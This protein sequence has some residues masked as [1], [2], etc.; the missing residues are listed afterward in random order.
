MTKSTETNSD[1]FNGSPDSAGEPA[2]AFERGRPENLALQALLASFEGQTQLSPEDLQTISTLQ[3]NFEAKE[4]KLQTGIKWAEVEA[5]LKKSPEKLT[6]L[7]RLI[8]HG[9]LTVT[10]KLSNGNFRFDDLSA[11]APIA[12]RN[13]NFYEAE[14]LAAQLGAELMEPSVYDT[15]RSKG[16]M[17]DEHTFSWLRTTK[18]VPKTRYAKYGHLG[19]SRNA[20][21]FDHSLAYGFRCSLEV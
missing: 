15:F 2:A 13:V 19:F 9:E 4:A 3:A 6:I 1:H 7:G 8:E 16:I 11:E 14:V 17:L 5:K 21:A 20:H 12:H 10:A 18:K